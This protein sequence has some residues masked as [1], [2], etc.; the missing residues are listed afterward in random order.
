MEGALALAAV[1]AVAAGVGLCG[2]HRE[3]LRRVLLGTVDPRP[4]ALFRIAFGLCLLALVVETAPLSTY[5]FSD[6]G[7]LP[8][9]AA[10]RLFDGP[11]RYTDDTV[12]AWTRLQYVMG[13]HW[14]LLHFR[15]DPAFAE[16]HVAALAVACVGLVLGCFT[17]T[18][19]VLAWL[20]LAGLLRRG[21]A[22]WGGEQIFTGFAFL[23]IFA[24]SGAAYGV[25]AWRRARALSRDQ[26]LD[27]REGE[28]GGAPPSPEHPHGL[29]AIYPRI[30]AWPQALLL[31]QL[32]IAYAANGWI[33][34][35]ATWISGDTLRL[36]LHLDRYVRTDWHAL[37][38]ALGPW[39]FRLATWGVL[40]WERLFP[41]MIVGLWLRAVARSGAPQ[42]S[43]PAR[44]ASRACWIVL[45]GAMAT[46]AAVPGALAEEPG[47]LASTRSA[48]LGVVAT[49]LALLVVLGPARLRAPRFRRL[50][51]L[52]D[53]RPWIAF[54]LMFHAVSLV[55]FELGAFVS[56]TASAY[57]LCGVG[58]ACVAGV[59]RLARVLGRVGVPV[60]AHLR[61]ERAVPPEDPSL[62]HLHRDAAEL[63]RW[64]WWAAGALV[65][66]GAVVGLLPASRSPAWWHAGWF[67]A[68]G[69]LVALGWRTARRA[70]E[71]PPSAAMPWAHGPAGRLAA[72][73]LFA[74][75]LVALGIWQIPKWPSVPWRDSARELVSPWMDLSFTKQLW[76]MFAPNGPVR[77]QTVRTTI[78]D[79]DG[80]AHDLR[81][82]LEH[83]ENLR[84]PYLFHDRWRKIDEAMSGYRSNLAPWHARWQCRR[85]ALE[86]DGEPPAEVVLERVATPFPPMRPLDAQAFFWEHAQV[87][88]LVRVRCRDE[89]FA[90]LDPEIRERHG[91]PPAPPGS[92]VAPEPLAPR[93]NPLAPLWW[94]CA[95]V[96]AGA[97][98]AWSREDSRRAPHEPA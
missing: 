91:L 43:G 41:L 18:C 89:P 22:H 59:Q 36:S 90:Q 33:K 44:T 87:T 20:L 26:R 69:G 97:L 34:T 92:L 65:L 38:V 86:H 74:Y 35:G 30:P 68:A 23:L 72:G 60:P 77:N 64:A 54:G 24:R 55:L 25:D 82:E 83:P 46:W 21:N 11:E 56:A 19:A 9:A 66:T 15:D 85:W 47:T 45:A 63:P 84:R 28:G 42:L 48:G 95:L 58:P 93:R 16:A 76:V 8:S 57:V 80:V 61:R 96:L 12:S 17:R 73:G 5:L 67:A 75:H 2:L 81:T 62:P 53:P 32:G 27:L 13:G 7:L 40:W 29:A 39:P 4:L 70:R 3:T 50:Q 31:V 6:E 51:W 88:P 1:L 37:A 78:V 52:V 98:A 14:S 71:A 79:R 94:G 10:P 49:V